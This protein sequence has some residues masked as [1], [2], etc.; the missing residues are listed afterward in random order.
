MKGRICTHSP[1]LSLVK[2]RRY[3]KNCFA[4]SVATVV[5]V[6]RKMFGLLFALF[7][8]STTIQNEVA[9]HK[10]EKLSYNNLPR[11]A[12]ADLDKMFMRHKRSDDPTD[13]R[14]IEPMAN[15]LVAEASNYNTSPKCT[16]KCP[17]AWI[18]PQKMERQVVVAPLNEKVR[19]NCNRQ[20]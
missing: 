12:A 13:E 11:D 9:C 18:N 20:K 8:F 5:Q 6:P 14:S 7:A 1:I 16:T 10:V 3:F 4:P 2:Q 17:P 15:K 19:V